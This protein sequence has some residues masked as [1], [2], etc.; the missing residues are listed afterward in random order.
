MG[1]PLGDGRQA[2]EAVSTWLAEVGGASGDRGWN[3]LDGSAQD[4]FSDRASYVGIASAADWGRLRWEIIDET[5]WDGVWHV[6]I[7]SPDRIESVPDFVLDAPLA[8]RACDD[9]V[10][11]GLQFSIV[12]GP[13]GAA[14]LSPPAR[15]GSGTQRECP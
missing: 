3:L 14:K 9:D 8:V 1:K 4:M 11:I 15:T 13:T 5:S 10:A 6:R 2:E 12:I 7:R